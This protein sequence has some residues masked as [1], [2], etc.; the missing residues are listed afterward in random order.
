[1]TAC[2]PA[3]LL[4]ASSGV[5]GRSEEGSTDLHADEVYGVAEAVSEDQLSEG[6]RARAHER[7]LI[8]V[9]RLDPIKGAFEPPV[10]VVIISDFDCPFCRRVEET[11][12]KLEYEYGLEKVRFVWKQQP[13]PFHTRAMP[14]HEAAMAA[15]EVAGKDAFGTLQ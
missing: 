9:G 3:M 14:L 4:P 1:M 15:F 7:A 10:T 6:N 2:T 13:L 12:K 8:P 11:L 5:T